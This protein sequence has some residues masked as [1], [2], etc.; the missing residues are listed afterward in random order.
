[1]FKLQTD[2]ALRALMYLASTGQQASVQEI[3]RA[4]GIS[5]DHLFKVVQQLV[6]L[7]LVVTRPGRN[8]GVR[9]SRD[10]SAMTCGEVVAGFEGR[11]GL[12][13]CVRSVEMSSP[14][15]AQEQAIRNAM[16][17]AE[18]AMYEAFE[19]VTIADMVRQP[20]VHEPPRATS[21]VA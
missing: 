3:A 17:A 10:A 5:R 4:H 11:N 12:L 19:R 1:M 15:P 6:R 16:I 7:G 20:T 8:G 21:L 18:A 14:M 2:Y 13:P 9:L